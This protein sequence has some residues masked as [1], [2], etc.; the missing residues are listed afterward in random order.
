[1]GLT[2]DSISNIKR[3]ALTDE[4]AVLAA[5]GEVEPKQDW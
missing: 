2:R 3:N 1:L 5:I 4:K